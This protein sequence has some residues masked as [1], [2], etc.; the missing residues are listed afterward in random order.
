MPE[1]Q[2]EAHWRVEGIQKEFLLD[3]AWPDCDA[4]VVLQTISINYL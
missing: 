4:D 3:A 2:T 1:R